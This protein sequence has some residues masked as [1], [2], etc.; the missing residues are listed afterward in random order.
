VIITTVTP[1]VG[2]DAG[3]TPA[4]VGALPIPYWPEVTGAGSEVV[5]TDSVSRPA[6]DGL[7]TPPSSTVRLAPAATVSLAKKPQVAVRLA[8]EREQLPMLVLLAVRICELLT[9]LS[10]LPDGNVIVIELL[11][12]VESAP[13]ED[14]V[15]ATA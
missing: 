15:N 14:A 11:A 8:W 1:E 13:V 3:L 10:E 5:A 2:P 12:S 9:L 4:T 6:V 7:P